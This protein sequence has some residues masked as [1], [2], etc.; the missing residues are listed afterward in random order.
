MNGFHIS[1]IYHCKKSEYD[2]R[3]KFKSCPIW[4]TVNKVC[5][6]CSIWYTINKVCQ[7][8]SIWY[9]INKVYVCQSCS[10]IWYTVNKVCQSCSIWYTVNKVCQSCP[11]WHTVFSI[12]RVEHTYLCVLYTHPHE[13]AQ[14]PLY[15]TPC[16]IWVLTFIK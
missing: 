3:N 7:S 15:H 11:I 8:C 6:S 10:I 9:T 2:T 13:C 5:Q 16:Q 14:H 1:P 4:Y 12:I